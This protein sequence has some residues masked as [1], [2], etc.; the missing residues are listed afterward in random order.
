MKSFTSVGVG[1]L[2]F[3]LF[4]VLETNSADDDDDVLA[5]FVVGEQLSVLSVFEH[6]ETLIGVV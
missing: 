3:I 5:Q 4:S 1:D 6:V 2:D